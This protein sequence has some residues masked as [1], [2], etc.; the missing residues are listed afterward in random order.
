MDYN[1]ILVKKANWETMEESKH[2]ENGGRKRRIEQ[3]RENLK[4]E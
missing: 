3:S 4:K 2:N 1:D